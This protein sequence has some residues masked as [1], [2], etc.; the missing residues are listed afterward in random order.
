MFERPILIYSNYCPHSQNFINS[1]IKVPQLF[2]SF[3]RINID[4]NPE[5]NTRNPVFY[6]IQEILKFKITDVPTIIVDNG[7]YVLFGE[8]AFK[9]LE[10]NINRGSNV[11]VEN[12]KDG[13]VGVG[14]AGVG[15]AG[16][17]SDVLEGFN[18]IEMGS[19][20]DMYSVYGSSDMNDARDQ[21]FQFLDRMNM[22]IETPPEDGSTDYKSQ[23]FEQVQQQRELFDNNI[24]GV[25]NPRDDFIKNMNNVYKSESSSQSV[26]QKKGSKGD[27]MDRKYKQLLAERERESFSNTQMHQQMHQQG[28]QQGRQQ[29]PQRKINFNI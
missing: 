9:W 3:V 23:N 27:E 16:V 14:N 17:G 22:K 26:S 1:L 21:C 10:Y 5:T 19:F 20:S 24:Q 15:N 18:P 6:D 28:S 13:N 7:N 11:N 29:G 4:I 8:E 2:E 12:P 25:G